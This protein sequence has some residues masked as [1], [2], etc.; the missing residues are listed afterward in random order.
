VAAVRRDRRFIGIDLN[1]H[2]LEMGRRRLVRVLGPLFANL[3]V[4]G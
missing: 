2:Y 3:P 4:E 1:A